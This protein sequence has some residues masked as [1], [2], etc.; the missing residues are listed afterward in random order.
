MKHFWISGLVALMVACGGPSK[1][2]EQ[3]STDSTAVPATEAPAAEQAKTAALSPDEFANMLA[4]HPEAQLIDVRTPEEVAE[5]KIANAQNMDYNA[6]DFEQKIAAL[7]KSKP[8]LLYCLRGKR[9]DG[10][11]EMMIEKG[12]KEVYHLDGGISRWQEAGKEVVK[13]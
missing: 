2:A 12:F 10:A 8:V 5:G 7:D 6:G 11:R 1:Q 13:Q 4:Q 9:S 3:A